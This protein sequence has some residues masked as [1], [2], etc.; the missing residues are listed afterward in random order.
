MDSSVSESADSSEKTAERIAVILLVEDSLADVRLM[1][2]VL[3]ET[4][5]PHQ[6]VVAGDGERALRVMRGQGEYANQ[7]R[8]DIVLLDLNLPGMDGREVLRTIKEDPRMRRVPVLVLSTSTAES[9]IVASYDA[10]ANCYLSKPVD[11]ADFFRLAEA[12]RDFWLRLVLLPP[13][14]PAVGL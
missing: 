2:E 4:G 5:L 10:H 9:D 7:V 1:Q 14:L 13:R 11:L 6:L 12:L 3:R 8:P